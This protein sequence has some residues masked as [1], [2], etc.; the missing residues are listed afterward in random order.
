MIPIAKTKYLNGHRRE[1]VLWICSL[2][3]ILENHQ[4]YFEDKELTWLNSVILSIEVLSKLILSGIDASELRTIDN[5]IKAIKPKLYVDKLIPQEN[6]VIKVSQNLIYDLAEYALENCKHDCKKNF[7]TCP[8][9][10]L[11]LDLL[12]PPFIV[13]GPCQFWRGEC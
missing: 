6:P 9:R 13:D 12:V 10:Q 2:Q 8:R 7:E 5:A 11:F 3:L 1:L 4:D